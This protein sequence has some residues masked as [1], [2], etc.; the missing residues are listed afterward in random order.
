ME[1]VQAARGGRFTM[2]CYGQALEDGRYVPTFVVTDQ[3][4]GIA[5]E[6]KRGTA[7]TV[8]TVVEAMDAAH[9]AAEA[10]LEAAH[11]DEGN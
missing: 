2:R 4:G 1:R 3:W 9:A 10:W 8:E 7:E 6:V 11:P 5:R